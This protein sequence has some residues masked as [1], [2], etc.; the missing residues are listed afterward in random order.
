[1][2][3]KKYLLMLILALNV[4]FAQGGTAGTGAIYEMRSLIDMPTAGIL[5][6]GAV[7]VSNDFMPMG[8]VISKLEVGVFQDFSFG[9]SYG[10]SQLIGSGSIGWYKMPGVNVK[11]RVSNETESY[12]ALT[13]GFD[14]QGKGVYENDRYEIKSPG[15]FLA[16]S[17]N[18]SLLGYISF[19][20]VFNY[21]FFENGDNDR[22]LNIM[23]GMEK[24]IGKQFSLLL[25]YNF[26]FNDNQS[27]ISQNNIEVLYTKK[28]GYL[29]LGFR[30]SVGEDITLGLDL[31]DLL[32]NG[33]RWN[34]GGADRALKLEIIKKIF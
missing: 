32:D 24:T 9:I 4:L 22:D 13:L 34:A 27:K 33:N 26:C 10:A 23:V 5:K 21:S 29:N 8:V 28:K 18:Y 11:Y 2:Y 16:I 15:I 17:K 31:R 19:H 1:M 6:K 7:A 12:P 3:L 14:S 30:W 20:G 25:D